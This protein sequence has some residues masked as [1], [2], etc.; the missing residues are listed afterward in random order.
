MEA[1]TS[2]TSI[3]RYTSIKQILDLDLLP[4]PPKCGH[5]GVKH[6]RLGGLVELRRAVVHGMKHE[7]H[8]DTGVIPQ[9]RIGLPLIDIAQCRIGSGLNQEVDPVD[10]HIR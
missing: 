2:R 9:C 8:A 7:V 4:G 6:I 1:G 5:H 3:I 10:G